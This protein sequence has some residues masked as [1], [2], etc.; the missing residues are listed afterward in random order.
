MSAD[1]RM[2]KIFLVFLSL[3]ALSV[4]TWELITKIFFYQNEQPVE[5]TAHYMRYACGNCYPQWKVDKADAPLKKIIGE[6]VEVIFEGKP[7]EDYLS[8]KENEE[9]ITYTFSFQGKIK[10]TISKHYIFEAQKYSYK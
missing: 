2:K 6:D 9:L 10:S 1:C 5:I 4:A 7:V 8:R 3:I